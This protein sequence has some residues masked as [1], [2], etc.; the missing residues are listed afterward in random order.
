MIVLDA[1]AAVHLLLRTPVGDAVQAWL[2]DRP[3]PL[4]APGLIDLEV[5]HVLRR[6]DK[7]GQLTSTA[8]AAALEV[9]LSAPVQRWS[10]EDLARRIWSLRTTLTAYDAAYVALAEMLDA[11]LVTADAKLAASHG[12]TARVD[13]MQA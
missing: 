2:F 3:Q 1:S 4:H 7:M 11:T 12:H 6:H 13:V 10:H 8:A 5:I 9:W